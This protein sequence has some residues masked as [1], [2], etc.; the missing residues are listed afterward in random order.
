M[1]HEH[2]GGD[3]QQR[4]EKDPENSI[5]LEACRSPA[6]RC[7]RSATVSAQEPDAGARMNSTMPASAAEHG[8]AGEILHR[9]NGPRAKVHR[10]CIAIRLVESDAALRVHKDRAICA[11][12]VDSDPF[13]VAL[14]VRDRDVLHS[15]HSMTGRIQYV[16]RP[17]EISNTAPVV[18]AHSCEA[19]NA[20]RSAISSTL[21]KRPRGIFESM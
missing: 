9:E 17:P 11:N 4:D 5:A 8:A 3:Q 2:E 19:Q 6:R 14:T 20:T 1:N 12:I 7:G 13:R 21:T 18:N 16:A 10:H 15:L